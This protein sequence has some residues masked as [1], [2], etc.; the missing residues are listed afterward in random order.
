MPAMR[1][2]ATNPT[3]PP[4]QPPAPSDDKG[5]KSGD[6]KPMTITLMTITTVK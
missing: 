2:Q 4:R 1:L 6:N 3:M 5:H